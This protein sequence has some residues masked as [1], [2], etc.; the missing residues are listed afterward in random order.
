[1]DRS[2]ADGPSGR[3]KKAQMPPRLSASTISAP[4]CNSPPEVHRC[5]AQASAPVT[6]EAD[7]DVSATPQAVLNG[8]WL[9]RLSGSGLALITPRRYKSRSLALGPGLR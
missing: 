8:I 1:M 2:L 3:F 5:G 9:S 6:S 7:A 4:P